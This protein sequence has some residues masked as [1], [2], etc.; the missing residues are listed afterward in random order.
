M[1][2][3]KEN[4]LGRCFTLRSAYGSFRK[5]SFGPEDLKKLNEFAAS[6]KGWCSILIKDKRTQDLNKV[7]SIAKWIHL[8]QVIINQRTKNFRFNLST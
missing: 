8:K 2:T 4:F 7:I 5:V 1:A 3:Q 6:N